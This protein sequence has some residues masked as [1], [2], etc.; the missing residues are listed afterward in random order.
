[1][2][3]ATSG[4]GTIGA[5]A[6]PINL[7]TLAGN[8]S[9]VCKILD[10]HTNGGVVNNVTIAP[11]GVQFATIQPL[12]AVLG[13]ALFLGPAVGAPNS[14]AFNSGSALA[15]GGIFGLAPLPGTPPFSAGPITVTPAM[16]S[17]AICVNTDPIGNG[18]GTFS[19]T[20]TIN[21]AGVGPITIPV[22]MIV[23]NGTT[24]TPPPS[25]NFS[26]MGIF[27]PS[28]P[29]GAAQGLFAVDQNGNNA[30]DLP[31]DRIVQ[32][33]LAGDI[34]VAG[35]WDGTGV[36]RIGV[37]RPSNGH[38]YLDVNNN[39][40]WDGNGAGLDLD[41]QFGSP[42]ATCVPSSAAG[43]AACQ[44]IPVVG[45]WTGNGV[46]RLGIFRGGLFFLD[47]QNPTAAGAHTSFTTSIFGM[48]G[49]IPVAANWNGTG[50]TDQIG[51][52]RRGVWYVNATGDGA[53]HASDP[54]YTFGSAGDIPVV[55][56]WNGNGA[57]RIGVFSGAGQWFLDL[58][59]DHV[60][61]NGFDL[62]APFGQTG[63]L[64][65]VGTFTLP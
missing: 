29:V 11:M 37:Y 51:V 52:Y 5:T 43:L 18:T 60:F 34:P 56:N 50:A 62:I 59:N 39:G 40:R 2:V 46:S 61:T 36:I 13:G 35:D 38:W 14:L 41:V 20:V 53:F 21:G 54:V 4:G 49:D 10:I 55:G 17:F 9:Q 1:M 23:S 47:N 31:A 16:Q 48:P 65:F 15:N 7:L 8:S 25:G 6:A 24:V 64:P 33:G 28:T 12:S 58:N 27:R 63:D 57:K 22:N 30:F 44:D 19:T 3:L 26:S 42:S 45:S 32:F